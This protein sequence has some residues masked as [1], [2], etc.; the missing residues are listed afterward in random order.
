MGMVR[1]MMKISAA[2]RTT[3]AARNTR[4]SRRL[5]KK[6]MAMQQISIS[7]ARTAMRRIIW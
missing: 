3:M 2:P 7:G 1:R 4:L 6:H 5:M